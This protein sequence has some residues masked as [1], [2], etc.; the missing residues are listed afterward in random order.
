MR[1][2]VYDYGIGPREIQLVERPWR[3]A[4]ATIARAA[5]PP[6]DRPRPDKTQP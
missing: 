5:A 1:R 2:H 6:D 3:L 4:V